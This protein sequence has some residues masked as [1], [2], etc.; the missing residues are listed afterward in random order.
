MEPE[1]ITKEK[2]ITML[3]LQ[4]TLNCQIHP[5]WRD[6]CF[7]WTRAIMAE[8][9]EALDH[10]GWK[11]WKKQEPDLPQVRLELVD[12]WH[13]MLSKQLEECSGNIE[14]AADV[15]T[16]RI[17][18]AVAMTCAPRLQFEHLIGNAARGSLAFSA[19]V[20]LMK[21]SEL[22]WDA[23]YVIYISKNV[24]N[25]FRQDHDYKAGSYIK[26]WNGV[27]DNVVL[28]QLMALKPDATPEQ[29][30]AKLEQV[31]AQVVAGAVPA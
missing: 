28:E 29:L 10:Y 3:Q 17:S 7:P 2:L 21:A 19:F 9:V 20:S 24:L 23:L 15:L 22:T 1:M 26:T 18:D 31:Y 6:Q 14:W 30:R 27:E 25:V 12:I 5:K 13:F 16:G 4:D 8:G 11:W